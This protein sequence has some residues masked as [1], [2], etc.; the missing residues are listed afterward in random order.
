[1]M[2]VTNTRVPRL[3]VWLASSAATAPSACQLHGAAT[4]PLTVQTA[5]MSLPRIAVSLRKVLIGARNGKIAL[6]GK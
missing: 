5:A 1:M 3:A 2:A 6:V 4:S